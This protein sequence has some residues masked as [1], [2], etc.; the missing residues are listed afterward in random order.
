MR[1]LYGLMGVVAKMSGKMSRFH[2]NAIPSNWAV[3]GMC[4]VFFF[5]AGESRKDAV[6]NGKTPQVM[7]AAQFLNLARTSSEHRY[8]AVHGIVVPQ[9]SLTLE[10]SH[11]SYDLVPMIDPATHQG[12]FIKTRQGEFSGKPQAVS[13]SGMMRGVSSDIRSDLQSKAANPNVTF[14][15]DTE[16]NAGQTPGD[17]VLST[18]LMVACGLVG[19]AFLLSSLLKHTIFQRT[20]ASSPRLSNANLASPFSSAPMSSAPMSSAP[21]S[22]ALMSSV[23]VSSTPIS[24]S[25]ISSSPI[26]SSISSATPSTPNNPATATGEAASSASTSSASTWNSQNAANVVAN[27][28]RLT[29]QLRLSEKVARRFLDVPVSRVRLENDALAFASNIDASSRMYGVVTQKRAG[30]WL[31]MPNPRSLTWQEGNLYHGFSPRPA[32]KLNFNDSLNKDKKSS[33]I[34]AFGSEAARTQALQEFQKEV[35]RARGTSM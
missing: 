4:L 11:S 5:I 22:S 2:M 34:L 28:L 10:E 13:V 17:P 31:M 16:L 33:A 21:M 23:P 15:T 25:S 6:S 1:L 24:S 12:F 30:L 29:G 18:L 8:V 9:A 27:E 26:S 3:I 19:G 35:E 32:L 20:R 7:T 14:N